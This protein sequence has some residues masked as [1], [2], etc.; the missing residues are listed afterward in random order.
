MKLDIGKS[1]KIE[2]SDCCVVG[3]FTSKLVRVRAY[4]D[5]NN[6]VDVYELDYGVE[7]FFENGVRIEARGGV[8]LHEHQEDESYKF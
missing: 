6:L 7:L 3:E 8:E 1:Y 2:I 4:D 5:Y